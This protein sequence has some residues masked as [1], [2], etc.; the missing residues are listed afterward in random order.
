MCDVDL[1]RGIIVAGGS[2]FQDESLTVLILLGSGMESCSALNA[3][4]SQIT[5]KVM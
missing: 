1:D 3:T 4:R 2:P 5:Q